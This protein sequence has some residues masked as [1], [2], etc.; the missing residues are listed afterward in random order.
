MQDYEACAACGYQADLPV[1]LVGSID[2]PLSWPSQNQLGANSRG[3]S[4]HRYRKARQEFASSL[5]QALSVSALPV[6]SVRRRAWMRR[7]YR[8]GKRAYDVANLIG[9]GK[10]I[11][12]V[13]VSRGL[14]KD[15]S[16][17]W[18]EGIY[19]QSP[20]PEDLICITLYDIL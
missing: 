5:H 12:D 11:V 20:G 7:V 16:P 17:K 9:G 18:F 15:D 6:G 13:L 4:G 19:Q 14:I 10:A 2:L 3:F 8:P 1:R